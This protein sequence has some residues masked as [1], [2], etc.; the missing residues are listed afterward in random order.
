[1][2]LII[3]FIN[4]YTLVSRAEENKKYINECRITHGNGKTGLRCAYTDHPHPY[5]PFSFKNLHALC[6]P[7]STHLIRFSV[8]EIIMI[9][10]T[11]PFELISVLTKARKNTLI[12]QCQTIWRHRL[13]PITCQMIT[14][15]V[16]QRHHHHHHLSPPCCVLWRNGKWLLFVVQCGGIVSQLH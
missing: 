10:I 7:Y 11:K 2:Y 12:S 1:M 4:E 5:Y 14:W 16:H 3:S 8:T 6:F 15:Q 9:T 13:G